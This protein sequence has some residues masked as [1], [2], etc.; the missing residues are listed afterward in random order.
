MQKKLSGLVSLLLTVVYLLLFP[1]WCLTHILRPKSGPCNMFSKVTSDVLKEKC[2][3]LSKLLRTV[4]NMI[5]IIVFVKYT[6]R[7][8]LSFLHAIIW[9]C[10]Q[11][12]LTIFWIFKY[13]QIRL[14]RIYGAREISTLYSRNIF[15]IVTTYLVNLL[16]G[17]KK[18]VLKEI[19]IAVFS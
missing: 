1:W 9:L 16:L 14:C 11:V 19:L 5:F 10:C 7:N 3:F 17:T 15:V 2:Y 13:C 18:Q 12:L 6:F 8:E 4:K